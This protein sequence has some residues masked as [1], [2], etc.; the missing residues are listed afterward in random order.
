MKILVTGFTGTLGSH[1]VPMLLD[2]GHEVVGYSRDEAKQAAFPAHE[3]LTMYMGDVRDPMRLVEASRDCDLIFHLAALKRVE[4][5]EECP[6]EFISTNILGTMHVLHAQR[7]NRVPRV[8]LAS[9]DKSVYPINLYGATKM[10]AERLVLRNPN[11]TVARYGNVIAS[12]GSAIPA[13]AKALRERKPVQITDKR[14]TRYWIT[15]ND[16][17]EFVYRSAMREIGGLCIPPLKA[18]PVVSLVTVLSD[19]LNV[20]TF[21]L[22]D[23]GLRPGE[24]INEDLRRPEEGGHLNSG[25]RE[26]WFST[27]EMRELLTHAIEGI[28]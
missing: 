24:K 16:A 17:A 25:Q 8:V 18:Y 14:M 3:K 19:V 6:E 2:D 15:P 26:Y 12:R 20:P 23:V 13:F 22:E 11:N 28:L 10:T 1:L 21:K 9:T 27:K 7:V 5:G 4:R